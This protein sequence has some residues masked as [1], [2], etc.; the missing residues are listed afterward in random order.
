VIN[1]GERK[2][3]HAMVLDWR[4]FIHVMD[5]AQSHVAAIDAPSRKEKSFTASISERSW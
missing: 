5:L 4:D 2:K 3:Q 1:L